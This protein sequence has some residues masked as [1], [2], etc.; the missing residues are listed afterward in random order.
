VVTPEVAEPAQDEITITHS[1][2]QSIVALNS[3]ACSPD[4]GF[5]TTENG[6]LRHFVLDDFDIISDFAVSEVSF[7]IESLAITQ[8]VTVN[9]YTMID[10]AG[11]FTYANFQEIGSA[12]ATLAAQSMTIVEVPV[13]GT[14]PAGSTLVVEVDVPDMS[15]LGAFFIGS[16]SDGQTAPSYLRSASCGITDP[17]DLAAIGFPGMHIVMNVTGTTGGGEPGVCEAPGDV[18]WLSVSPE[19]GTTPAGGSSEV[20]VSFDSTGLA[21]GEYAAVLCV[22]SNDPASPLV[23]V[24]VSLTVVEDGGGEPVVCDE[25]ITGTH[26]GPL[27]VEEGVTCL[28]AGSRVLG[29]INVLEGA[30]LVATAA[31][32]QG[33]ISAIGATVVEVV[34]SQ[35]TGPVLVSGAT[36]SVSLFASQVTGSVSVLNAGAPSTVSG[37]T[38]I[39]S[40]SCFGNVPEPADQGLPNTATGGKLG[41][42]AN[43]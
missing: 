38:I 40:L 35:V 8:T 24:P 7:A 5:S 11:P 15:G 12:D 32:V 2:S 16:N 29:E 39:G 42:C 28:A 27:T 43:L 20:T 33:P 3:V 13:T 10:P 25:T 14:A 19:S 34:F 22:T 41:Q 1:A 9:L 31:V 36:E 30:G 23:Q 26:S 4:G 18:P 21:V 37:N 6:Y 17:T